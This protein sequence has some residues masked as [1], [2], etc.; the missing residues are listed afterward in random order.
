[1]PKRVVN[2]GWSYRIGFQ[3]QCR[4]NLFIT[5]GRSNLSG[6]SLAGVG[7]RSAE[8]NIFVHGHCAERERLLRHI[9]RRNEGKG[10]PTRYCKCRLVSAAKKSPKQI[11]P[12]RPA[13]RANSQLCCVGATAPISSIGLGN[14]RMVLTKTSTMLASNWASAQRSNSFRASDE[15]RPF[16]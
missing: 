4:P 3:Q 9:R 12:G 11:C 15:G 1:M 2:K 8:A 10:F 5:R 6:G 16:L 14:W 7:S 13:G